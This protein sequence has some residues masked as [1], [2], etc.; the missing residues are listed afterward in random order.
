MKCR[1]TQETLTICHV[2]ANIP[3]VVVI[4]YTIFGGC[5]KVGDLEI[6]P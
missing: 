5:E 2:G 6:T 3:A 1:A 4:V